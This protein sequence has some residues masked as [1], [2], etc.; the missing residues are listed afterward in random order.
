MHAGSQDRDAGMNATEMHDAIAFLDV[1]DPM[2]ANRVR[3]AGMMGLQYATRGWFLQTMG[4][5]NAAVLVA[6]EVQCVVE[7]FKAE[8]AGGILIQ[9]K[10]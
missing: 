5:V 2:A 10:R 9:A 4:G 3:Y 1:F 7:A 8:R 6:C